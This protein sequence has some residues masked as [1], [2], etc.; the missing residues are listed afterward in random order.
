MYIHNLNPVI[1]DWHIVTEM[2]LALFNR[3]N[4]WMVV[5]GKKL[6]YKLIKKI[7]RTLIQTFF[8]DY[9][10]Y[11]VISII[12]GGRIGYVLFY[13]LSYFSQIP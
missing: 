13:N 10:T 7:I 4:F 9:I 2:V 3:N 5:R 6:F 8:D 11:V 12:V 1:F